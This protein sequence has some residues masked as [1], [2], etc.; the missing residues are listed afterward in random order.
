VDEIQKSFN[1]GLV[2]GVAQCLANG[3]PRSC[4]TSALRAVGITREVI[5]FLD[6]D[7]IDKKELTPILDTLEQ[8]DG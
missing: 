7:D 3:C 1:R 4:A 2:F 5:E 6:L 8:P